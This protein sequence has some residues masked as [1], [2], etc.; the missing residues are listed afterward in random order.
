[1][2]CLQSDGPSGLKQCSFELNYLFLETSRHIHI[3]KE[4]LLLLNKTSFV[5]AKGSSIHRNFK[6][7]GYPQKTG[8]K[9]LKL[10]LCEIWLGFSETR[11]MY[12]QNHIIKDQSGRARLRTAPP[13]F[14]A[15][16]LLFF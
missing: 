2:K 12:L 5:G 16:L 11:M 14:S 10:P 1:M 6:F 4:I 13:G 9:K 7:L 3:Y 8:C 15:I